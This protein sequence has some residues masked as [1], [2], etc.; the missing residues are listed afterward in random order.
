[1]QYPKVPK[2]MVGMLSS[3]SLNRVD[4]RLVPSSTFNIEMSETTGAEMS[5]MM[6]R[7]VAAKRKKVPMWWM[8]PVRAMLGD[9][10]LSCL[11]LLLYLLYIAK[12]E[13]AMV[14]D[15]REGHGCRST[16]KEL[17]VYDGADKIGKL[18]LL[19]REQR[20]HFIR[21]K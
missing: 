12:G 19:G 14:M 13:L 6:S 11:M 5:V 18:G 15:E 8:K 9:V 2:V 4:R 17:F 1:M 10:R 21:S 16:T 3:S 7:T 20:G